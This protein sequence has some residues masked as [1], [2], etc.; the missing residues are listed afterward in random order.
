MC[1]LQ[2][3]RTLFHQ[4]C[5][6]S[7]HFHC[8]AS[9]GVQL[10]LTT[11]QR[12]RC[13]SPRPT[14]HTTSRQQHH[15]PVTDLRSARPAQQVSSMAESTRRPF[16]KSSSFMSRVVDRNRM[17]RSE[18]MRSETVGAEACL[19]SCPTAY[20]RSG[21]NTDRNNKRPTCVQMYECSSFSCRV[22]STTRSFTP[23]VAHFLV[24]LASP[25]SCTMSSINCGLIINL[26]PSTVLSCIQK[27]HRRLA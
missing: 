14:C 7:Q 16:G 1:Q 25:E 18:A 6:Y 11:A 12:I 5:M 13:L 24:E 20:C 19:A 4:K 21:R 17:R 3:R 9:H 23:A 26:N 27:L 15:S 10:R 22:S 8:S 2:S